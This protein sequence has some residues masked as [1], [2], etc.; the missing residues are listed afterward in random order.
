MNDERGCVPADVNP[1]PPGARA[2]LRG[3]GAHAIAVALGAAA[4]ACV[5][6]PAPDEA[7]GGQQLEPLLGS[8][9]GGSAMWNFCYGKP[10]STPL[11]PDP[12]SL[13]QSGISDGKAVH[14]N[15]FWKDCH[16]DP[17]AVQE[18]GHATT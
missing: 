4:T 5:E 8:T 18:A 6:A 13:V 7:T 10:D 11:P 2:G 12:R 9:H 15:A 17:V 1:S 16:V 3:L 14:F